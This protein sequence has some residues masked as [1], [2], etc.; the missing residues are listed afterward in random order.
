[1]TL[2]FREYDFPEYDF[3]NVRMR[4]GEGNTIFSSYCIPSSS[5]LSKVETALPTDGVLL[6]EYAC[7]MLT[8]S[9]HPPPSL[10]RP[11]G[12]LLAG[13]RPTRIYHCGYVSYYTPG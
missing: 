5:P 12:Q 10:F 9:G 3:N 2:P 6:Y 7:F 8:T 11:A 13:L 4:K 1:M